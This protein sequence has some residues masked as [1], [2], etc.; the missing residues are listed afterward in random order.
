MMAEIAKA[1]TP[2][3]LYVSR[4]GRAGRSFLWD[5]LAA[6]AWLDPS[7]I[8]K[9]VVYFMDMD[10]DR[11]YGYGDTLIWNE[12]VKPALDLQ[13]VHTQMEV[14]MAKFGRQFVQLMSAPTPNAK[15][16]LILKLPPPPPAPPRPAPSQ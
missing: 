13:P 14:D 16:P 9:E 5:E 10:L 11:G 15:D 8:T 12:R 3:A 4:Y 7:V 6:A 1:K 2:A